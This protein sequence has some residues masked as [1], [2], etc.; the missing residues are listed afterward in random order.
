MIAIITLATSIGEVLIAKGIREIGEISTVRLS[1]L[2]QIALKILTNKFFMLGIF[3]MAIS[4]FTFLATLTEADLSLI[5]P[6]TA[7]S[8]AIK[9]FGAK[10][11][12][13]EQIS[14]DRLI[15]TLL[16][17]LGVALISLPE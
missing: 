8:F 4:F 2:L 17:C 11:V 13:K 16:V 1:A 15:G 14:R 12:L 3:L 10:L 6:A 7:I 9:T 5:V